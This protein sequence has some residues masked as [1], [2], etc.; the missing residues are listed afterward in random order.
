MGCGASS[1]VTADA[2]VATS[3]SAPAVGSNDGGSAGD[4]RS[5]A[6]AAGTPTANKPKKITDSYELAEVIGK[7]GFGEVKR[8]KRRADGKMWVSASLQPHFSRACP[9][10]RG[11]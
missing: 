4:R 2:M 3:V 11:I 7:G 5:V 9:C 10:W 1:P 8:A 6:K